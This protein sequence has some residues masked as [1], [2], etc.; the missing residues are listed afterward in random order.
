MWQCPQAQE[1]WPAWLFSRRRGQL[2]GE[3]PPGSPHQGRAMT[4]LPGRAIRPHWLSCL[5]TRNCHHLPPLCTRLAP[6][7]QGPA[8]PGGPRTAQTVT[9]GAPPRDLGCRRAW[10]GRCWGPGGQPA[11]GERGGLAARAAQG[12]GAESQP[13]PTESSNPPHFGRNL[14]ITKASL[15]VGDG[16]VTAPC[17]LCLSRG[18]TSGWSGG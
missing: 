13:I 8:Q 14:P 3:G 6:A 1:W 9:L 15:G 10:Q 17:G 18:V 12:T 7:S 5:W 16:E 2:P 11:H 4:R